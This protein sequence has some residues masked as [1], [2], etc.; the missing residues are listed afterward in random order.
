MLH[1]FRIAPAVTV[2]ALAAVSAVDSASASFRYQE[3]DIRTPFW[4]LAM[5]TARPQP[6]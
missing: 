2:L 3:Q 5:T 1:K 4:G 6:H